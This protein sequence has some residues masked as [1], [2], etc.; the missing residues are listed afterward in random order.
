MDRI[1]GR[2]LA[3]ASAVSILIAYAI[4]NSDCLGQIDRRLNL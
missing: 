4:A 2:R 3:L 1:T